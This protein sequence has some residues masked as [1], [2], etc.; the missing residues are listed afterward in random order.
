MTPQ[1]FRTASAEASGMSSANIHTY[2]AVP[3][4]S[5]RSRIQVCCSIR[6]HS[7]LWRHTALVWEAAL[8]KS[9]SGSLDIP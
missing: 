8:C 6:P 1:A 9:F 7:F 2:N 4:S 5:L 3:P